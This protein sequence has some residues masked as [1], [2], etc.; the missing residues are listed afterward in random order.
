MENINY[1]MGWLVVFFDLPTKTALD[2]KN[3]TNFRK[4]LMAD[5]YWMIQ[6][7]IYAR[8][9]VS[10]ERQKTHARRVKQ[11]LPPRGQVRCLFVTNAQWAKTFV[12]YGNDAPLGEPEKIPEQ[13]MLW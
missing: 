5:G 12:Y 9:C 1:K 11:I 3:Y 2:R 7:S 13:L 6:F 10:H 8:P 4:D